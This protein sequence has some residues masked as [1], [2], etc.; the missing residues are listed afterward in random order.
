MRMEVDL[1][2]RIV[3][4]NREEASRFYRAL[5][6]DFSDIKMGLESNSVTIKLTGLAPSRARALANSLLRMAQLYQRMSE[7]LR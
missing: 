2:L 1:R 4:E 6:P 5:L 7:E 3:F